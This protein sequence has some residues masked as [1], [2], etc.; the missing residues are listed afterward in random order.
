MKPII[1]DETLFAYVD[2][3]L[4]DKTRADVEAAIAA[5]PALAQRVEQQRSLRKLL[6]AAYAPVMDEAVPERLAAAARPPAKAR[7]LELASARESRRA[8]AAA[9]AAPAASAWTWKH[10]GGMA[11]CLVVGM[12]AGRSAWLAGATEDIVSA[13]G[14][15]VARGQLAQALSTQL[16]STQPNDARVKLGL[17][18]VSRTDEYCR[19]FVMASGT[20]GL[21]C[22]QGDEWQLRVLAQDKP[23]VDGQLRMASSPV[24]PAVLKVIEEQI[25]GSPLD[26]QSE[27]EALK[28]GWRPR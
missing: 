18:F 1:P 10:W 20:G 4:D 27:R 22:R 3:E 24:P 7:V 26:A 15:L 13:G 28:G 16:A 23:A 11:A 19:S 6:G 8:A 2:N 25:K 14:Q 21:A 12:V 5:D 9:A 17:S